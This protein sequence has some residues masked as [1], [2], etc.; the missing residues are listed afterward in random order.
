MDDE[1]LI[2][3]KKICYIFTQFAMLWL[4]IIFT[5]FWLVRTDYNVYFNPFCVGSTAASEDPGQGAESLEKES[6]SPTAIP[7]CSDRKVK[8]TGGVHWKVTRADTVST[9][10]QTRKNGFH[11]NHWGIIQ[12]A[13]IPQLRLIL[14]VLITTIDA[15]GHFETG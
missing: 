10:H 3:S 8:V 12:T 11:E 14:T 6:Y 2:T 4:T 1:D 7:S 15:M 13:A 9:A 5:V